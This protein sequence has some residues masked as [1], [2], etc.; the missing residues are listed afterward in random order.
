MFDVP[1]TKLPESILQPVLSALIQFLRKS[2]QKNLFEHENTHNSF[3]ENL[4]FDRFLGQTLKLL[5]SLC[6]FR[7]PIT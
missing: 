6:N 7:Y 5:S 2:M 3:F 4:A 1:E